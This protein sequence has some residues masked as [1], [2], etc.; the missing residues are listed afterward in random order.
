VGALTWI[1]PYA[2][3]FSSFL[4]IYASGN[5]TPS[6]IGRVA[7][8]QYKLDKKSN[9]WIHS[10][11]ANYLS[12]W[13][14][15][16]INDTVHHQQ[17]IEA[18]IFAQQERLEAEVV[19]ML[20]SVEASL[21]A[22]AGGSSKLAD[23]TKAHA[24]AVR[25]K[26]VR[27]LEQW[28]QKI[29]EDVNKGWWDFFWLMITKYRDMYQIKDFHAENYVTSA[30]RIS[31]PRWWMEQVGYWGSP[32]TPSLNRTSVPVYPIN[33]YSLPSPE[34]FKEAYPDGYEL[35]YPSR[36]NPLNPEYTA[37]G[38]AGA[39][40]AGAGGSSSSSSFL[41]SALLLCVGAGVGAAAMYLVQQQDRRRQ[42][43]V[44]QDSAA[45]DEI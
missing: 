24:L 37:A 22:L 25:D 23:G 32:G 7:A 13:Y 40:G 27:K 16:T 17:E 33:V 42:Y 20:T 43:T 14:R 26:A 38:S 29:G 39:G 34:R 2:P 3:H 5:Y 4:P 10:L 21:T 35:P 31:Y 9:F 15:Y 12:R 1:A 44:I 8:T 11:T 45:A 18:D 6:A 36:L 41:S 28:H 30:N 19:S